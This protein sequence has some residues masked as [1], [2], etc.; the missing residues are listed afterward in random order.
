MLG[1]KIFA[2][3]S[4]LQKQEARNALEE[5]QKK[6]NEVTKLAN[7]ILVSLITVALQK[8]LF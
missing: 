2:P 4:T 6:H 8:C 1:E 7:S 3:Q 5:I